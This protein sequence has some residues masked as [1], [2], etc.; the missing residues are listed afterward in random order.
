VKNDG[1]GNVLDAGVAEVGLAADNNGSPGTLLVDAGTLSLTPTGQSN[2]ATFGPVTMP[3]GRVWEVF[4]I[5]SITGSVVIWG[6]S[7]ASSAGYGFHN[8][9]ITALSSSS[10]ITALDGT[11]TMSLVSTTP[12]TGALPTTPLGTLNASGAICALESHLNSTVVQ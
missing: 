1:A 8:P 9:D 10:A 4:Q 5:N 6:Y 7:N 3:H 11:P 12:N 2:S